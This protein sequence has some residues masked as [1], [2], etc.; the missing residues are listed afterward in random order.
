VYVYVNHCIVIKGITYLYTTTRGN[1]QENWRN[2]SLGANRF[3]LLLSL[4]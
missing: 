4:S 2:S 3:L 1:A